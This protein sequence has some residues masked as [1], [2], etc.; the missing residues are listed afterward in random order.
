MVRRNLINE[1]VSSLLSLV[2]AK[3]LVYE[4]VVL[5]LGGCFVDSSVY[6]CL[7]EKYRAF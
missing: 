3:A 2:I 1:K 5:L 7:N 6:L 4:D